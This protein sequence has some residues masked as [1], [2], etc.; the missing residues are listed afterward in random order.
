MHDCIK[1]DQKSKVERI[2]VHG[3]PSLLPTAPR[4]TML[5]RDGWC[6]AYYELL[7]NRAKIGVREQSVRV[8]QDELKA[9]EE[10]FSAGTVGKLNVRRAEVSLANEE[11]ELFDAQTRLQN[12]YLRVNEL[13]GIV[14]NPKSRA[15]S[16]ELAG[17]LQYQG[18]RPDLTECLGHATALRP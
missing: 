2:P 12:S 3:Y 1:D 18:L 9:Q 10:R 7:L 13:C 6:V 14:T 4:P 8:M 15:H 5:R 17:A 11:P 16:I